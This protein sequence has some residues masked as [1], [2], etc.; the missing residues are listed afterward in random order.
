MCTL[1]GAIPRLQ[2]Q[3]SQRPRRVRIPL[4]HRHGEPFGVRQEPIVDREEGDRLGP[5]VPAHEEPPVP[6]L[7]HEVISPRQFERDVRRHRRRQVHGVLAPVLVLQVGSGHGRGD[8]GALRK[9]VGSAGH[10]IRRRE[11]GTLWQ[12]AASL[13]RVTTTAKRRS[14]GTAPVAVPAGES[15]RVLGWQVFKPGFHKK[16]YYSAEDCRR[17]VENFAKYSVGDEAPIKVKAKLGHDDEQRLANSLGYPN[18]GWVKECRPTPDGGFALD[19]DGVPVATGRTRR[20]ASAGT[21]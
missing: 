8:H 12:P 4:Q 1:N 21:P 7:R 19:I 2:H 10:P 17:V 6:P 14:F 18:Q 20:R 9:G 11:K 13:I 5:H 3:I 15:C 16:Q